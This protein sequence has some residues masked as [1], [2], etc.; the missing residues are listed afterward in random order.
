M[1]KFFITALS[2][3]LLCL[4]Q[5][6]R[7]QM[8]PIAAPAS[9]GEFSFAPDASNISSETTPE[10]DGLPHRAAPQLATSLTL[11][12]MSPEL[13]LATY[14]KRATRQAAELA[15]YSALMV[16]QAQLPESSQRG[17]FELERHYAAPHTLEFK[18]LQFTGDGFVKSNVITRLLQSEVDHVQKDDAA[19]TAINEA[20]YKFS[21]KGT[22][23]VQGR[24]MH[25]YQVKPR[26][27]RVGLFKGR[28]Y[29]DAYTGSLLYATGMVVKSPSFFVKKIEF[30]QEYADFGPFTFPVHIHSEAK[31][32]LVGR[33]V[34]DIYHRNYRPVAVNVESARG[35]P[36]AQ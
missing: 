3:L 36:A 1:R 10:L 23:M 5:A 21:Y 2:V 13:A 18:A 29:L 15:A 19:L 16:V 22:P 4:T 26:K 6:V 20:N 34:V 17:E 30:V 7:A 32:R 11:P 25:V 35:V 33:T 24:M 31:A 9:A 27:K 8:G 12:R 28:I 14:E